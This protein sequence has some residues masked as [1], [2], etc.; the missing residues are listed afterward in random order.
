MADWGQGKGEFADEADK[1]TELEISYIEP[2]SGSVRTRQVFCE[3]EEWKERFQARLIVSSDLVNSLSEA[4]GIWVG[5][6]TAV[7]QRLEHSR[8]Y[9]FYEL[10]RLRKHLQIAI[11]AARTTT[12][13]GTTVSLQTEVSRDDSTKSFLTRAQ[14]EKK[15]QENEVCPVHFYMPELYLDRYTMEMLNK[16]VKTFRDAISIEIA[17]ILE[18]INVVGAGTWWQLL[19]YFIKI[20]QDPIEL[21]V[22]CLHHIEDPMY[23]R[24][25]VNTMTN[26]LQDLYDALLAQFESLQDETKDMVSRKEQIRDKE[27]RQ[28]QSINE[29]NQRIKDADVE[30]EVFV[31]PPEPPEEDITEAVAEAQAAIFEQKEGNLKEYM[32]ESRRLRA[33]MQ[34]WKDRE[35]AECDEEAI[36]V[37]EDQIKDWKHRTRLAQGRAEKLD[38]KAD[39]IDDRV[40]KIEKKIA[41]QKE[42]IDGLRAK[43]A[44]HGPINEDS[45]KMKQLQR[46]I[47]QL[48]GETKKVQ[49]AM[50]EPNNRI[51][52]MRAQL[53]ELYK[54]LGWDWDMSDSE[55]EDGDEEPPYWKRRKIA[56]NGFLPFDQT[57]FLFGEKDFHHRRTRQ[58]V[59]RLQADQKSTLLAQMKAKR[60]EVD[61]ESQSRELHLDGDDP[62]AGP[63]LFGPTSPSG[64]GFRSHSRDPI[65]PVEQAISMARERLSL[66]G[67]R[68]ASLETPCWKR[69]QHMEERESKEVDLNRLLLLRESFESQLQQSVECFIDLLP[70]SG[71]LG[72]LRAKLNE[73]LAKLQRLP[74]E[75]EAWSQELDSDLQDT[76]DA[77]QGMFQ[78]AM[79]H[80]DQV[81]HISAAMIQS[82]RFSDLRNLLTEVLTSERKM[83]EALKAH[84][85]GRGR[86]ASPRGDSPPASP[87]SHMVSSSECSPTLRGQ[88][89]PVS[90]G[91]GL[92][93]AEELSESLRLPSRLH[94][95]STPLLIG[96]QPKKEARK[97]VDFGFRPDGAGED[98]LENWSLFKV[99]KAN[100]SATSG[101]GDSVSTGMGLTRS[102]G[103]TEFMSDNMRRKESKVRRQQ[104]ATDCD[105]HEYMSQSRQM[106][107]AWQTA[108]SPSLGQEA[109][110]WVQAKKKVCP[111]LPHL[112]KT[113]SASR[114]LTGSA[115]A[116]QGD[117]PGGM[118][119]WDK[120]PPR[121]N[122]SISLPKKKYDASKFG[123]TAPPSGMFTKW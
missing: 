110:P 120:A 92:P 22:G 107:E 44:E 112:M 85:G 4:L 93:T 35:E 18:K 79:S 106:N 108:S 60:Q 119:T 113:G 81:Q 68:H 122:L 97:K 6:F 116:I 73:S 36:K 102:T 118:S 53:K 5:R 43:L 96:M 67:V 104:G 12:R 21:V 2:A 56:A 27:L 59:K 115:A 49:A 11:E 3:P 114:S 89:A 82:V 20:G 19:A 95:Q 99:S 109:R 58:L 34:E 28:N 61:G 45:L 14:K 17:G 47:K 15:A 13:S 98:S 121:L 80:G 31:A 64:Y 7:H 9:Y 87:M 10:G 100:T 25:L 69:A 88:S 51:R 76:C 117:L 30:V 50:V 32:K 75:N 94:A 8:M 1:V 23:R 65:D 54:K 111:K 24:E 70:D 16:A 105:F 71:L 123:A 77:L 41:T 48:N 38:E 37:I 26:G 39:V 46:D 33:L 78:E 63:N 40:S 55:D 90:K 72:D 103:F 62:E 83:R 86:L 74:E 57:E 91:R 52:A 84:S 42:A 66:P 29:L 101:F